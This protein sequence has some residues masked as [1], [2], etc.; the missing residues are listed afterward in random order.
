[1]AR[2]MQIFHI[3]REQATRKTIQ[4]TTQNEGKRHMP[5]LKRKENQPN[6]VKAIT[7]PISTYKNKQI[8]NMN[9][10]SKKN[11]GCLKAIL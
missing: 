3:L 8:H 1:M 11:R 6:Q 4:D 7:I 9:S 5:I 10:R 2:N